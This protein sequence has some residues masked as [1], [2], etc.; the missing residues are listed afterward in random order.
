MNVA[1][2]ILIRTGTYNDMAIRPYQ[3]NTTPEST[4]QL[5]ESTAGG[6]RVQAS[7]LAGIAGQIIRPS[8]EAR[9]QVDIVGGW[10]NPRMRFMMEVHHQTMQGDT[11]IQYLTGYTDYDGV[12]N[13]GAVDQNMRFFVNNSITTRKLRVNTPYG[14][15]T[16]LAVADAAQVLYGNPTRN[17]MTL[18]SSMH[19]MRPE[20]IFGQIGNMHDEGTFGGAPVYDMRTPFTSGPLKKSSR[21]NGSSSQYLSKVLQTY[22]STIATADH[23]SDFS[24][25]ANTMA[26][27]VREPGISTDP[28]LGTL[29]RMGTSL[30]NEGSF[31]YGELCKICPETDARTDVIT[32]SNAQAATM[33]Q[34]GMS[35]N[36]TASTH[37]ALLSTILT[38]AVPSIMIDLMLTVVSFKVTNRTVGGQPFL[39]LVNYESFTQGVDL[40]AFLE[41][42]QQRFLAEVFRDITRDG[43]ID[44]EITGTFDLLGE[45]VIDISY[46]GNPVTR[47]VAPSFC[48]SLMAPV[49]AYDA[50]NV[51]MLATDV[52]TIAN[53]IS[54]DYSPL[55]DGPAIASG[56]GLM[57]GGSM[58]GG[59]FGGPVI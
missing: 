36:W 51:R 30:V 5:M 10:S 19:T 43:Q 34:R 25:L 27:T 16:Q 18:E 7:N 13:S 1:H 17:Y 21:S 48:D 53:A 2:L 15:N 57:G 44:M 56:G 52:D 50:E 11:Q 12:T 22:K 45:S 47:Y 23:T 59:G 6:K 9:G 29:S 8:S 31:T 42:F 3:A 38:H 20:D 28:F 46:M 14:V 54:M 33:H 58:A 4:M 35:D 41:N 49:V 39:Q 40:T 37:E 32:P 26:G 55:N 24:A